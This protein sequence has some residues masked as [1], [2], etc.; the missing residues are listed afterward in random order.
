MSITP[1]GYNYGIEPNTKHPFWKD[2]TD[3]NGYTFYEFSTPSILANT[4]THYNNVSLVGDTDS[5]N[6]NIPLMDVMINTELL[7]PFIYQN[8]VS[9]LVCEGSETLELKLT[10]L[11]SQFD[12]TSMKINAI[13]PTLAPIKGENGKDGVNGTDGVTPDITL[14]A[15][16]DNTTGTPNVSVTKSGTVSNP[17]FDM[18]FTGLKGEKGEQGENGLKGDT[19]V[20]PNITVTATVDDT[21]GTPTVNV[22]K[23]GTVTEPQFAFNFTGLKGESGGSSGK[24]VIPILETLTTGGLKAGDIIIFESEKFTVNV[25]DDIN[26]TNTYFY[27]DHTTT[28]SYAT[29]TMY[30]FK[31]LMGC[32][33]QDITGYKAEI[34]LSLSLGENK[35]SRF[36]RAL[37]MEYNPATNYINMHAQNNLAGAIVS[38]DSFS[39]TSPYYRILTAG[40]FEVGFDTETQQPEFYNYVKVIR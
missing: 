34:P 9:Y 27:D 25:R 8:G 6:V 37:Y 14:M 32:V 13:I 36:K 7:V 3:T 11:L 15:T 31:C 40:S 30:A 4:L 39:N 18:D 33:L 29:R 12:L 20:T 35:D 21:T 23:G 38:V 26:C 2:G 22:E 24:Q 1:Q 17:I 16:V 10:G 28:S 19:G 5:V